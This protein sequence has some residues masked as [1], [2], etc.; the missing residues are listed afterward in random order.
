MKKHLFLILF[1]SVLYSSCKKDG[2]NHKRED[3]IKTMIQGDW[4]FQSYNNKIMIGQLVVGG[5]SKLTSDLNASPH[6]HFNNDNTCDYGANKYT[7]SIKSNS[8]TDSLI[9]N[10]NN[11][12]KF[13][14]SSVSDTKLI[15]HSEYPN[16]DAY[17]DN[18]G[19][20]VYA[21]HAAIDAVLG[22]VQVP[23]P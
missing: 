18:T 12:T 13:Q 2:S 3:E 11:T 8:K 10:I 23:K 6:Y 4:Y 16:H 15:V 7:Y 21:D 20:I 17:Q 14:I 22:R 1:L 9:V 5:N 19:R